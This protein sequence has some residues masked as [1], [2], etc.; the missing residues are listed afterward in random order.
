MPDGNSILIVYNQTAMDTDAYIYIDI[1]MYVALTTGYPFHEIGDRNKRIIVSKSVFMEAKIDSE[2]V[3]LFGNSI[4][5]YGCFFSSYL[6][7]H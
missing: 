7:S 5:V 6:S 1:D 4:A 3:E 2:F